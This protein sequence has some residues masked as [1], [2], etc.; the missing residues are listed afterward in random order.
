MSR[1]APSG[2]SILLVEDD[3]DTRQALVRDLEAHGYRVTSAQDGRSALRAWEAQ[4]P[5]LVV[6]DLGLP[7]TDGLDV[8]RRLRRDAATPVLIL[9]AR[10]QELDK[11]AALELGADD[12]VTK[13]F[14]MR[15]LH[16]RLRV[17]LRRSANPLVTT[18]QQL[19]AGP[20]VL[21]VERHEV[22][23]GDREVLLAPREFE[24]LRVLLANAG[25]LV[26]HGRLLRAVWGSAYANEAH[27]VH[28]YVSQ[29]RRKLREA[30]PDGE[31]RDLIRP[32]PGVGYRVTVPVRADTDEGADPPP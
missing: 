18:G 24:V 1:P 15:E 28:V 12:Y 14:G 5:D 32:E 6:L 16:A 23:V 26:T 10:D 29:I 3:R 30:D 8:V 25:R 20:L 22:R 11:V 4:R 13:P 2:P 7:D 9:S 31:L 27:Y 19:V 17:L 21:D